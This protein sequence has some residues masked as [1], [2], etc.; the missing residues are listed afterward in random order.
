MKREEEKTFRFY[1]VSFYILAVCIIVLLS[2][3]VYF[4]GQK[5]KICI[6]YI[7]DTKQ[8]LNNDYDM[9]NDDKIDIYDLLEESDK[10]NNMK[11][12]ILNEN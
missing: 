6:E 7:E 3:V 12:Y 4:I 10:I 5:P 9:N 8:V 1:E 11:E 2:I